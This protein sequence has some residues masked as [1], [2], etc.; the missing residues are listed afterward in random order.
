MNCKKIIACWLAE[1]GNYE[2]LK[3]G[4]CVMWALWK[5]RNIKVFN[6]KEQPILS[7]IK[8]AVYWFNYSMPLLPEEEHEVQICQ[9]K[10]LASKWNPPETHWTKLNLDAAFD[11]Y[12][13][14]WEVVAR[15]YNIQ[16]K[17]CGTMSH[18]VMN[19]I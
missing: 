7:I 17:G 9:P 5:N 12:K 19:P 3:I 10:K 16:F 4:S 14:A 8:E 6:N 1:K 18:Q 11:N 2:A 13:G 15:D